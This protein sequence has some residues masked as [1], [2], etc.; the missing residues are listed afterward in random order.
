VAV[1]QKNNRIVEYCH[2]IRE[3]CRKEFDSNLFTNKLINI[4]KNLN[5]IKK[6]AKLKMSFYLIEK[7]DDS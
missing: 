7:S 5:K 6:E 1:Y 2:K 4:L 3:L